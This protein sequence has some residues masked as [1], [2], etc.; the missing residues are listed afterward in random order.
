MELIYHNILFLLNFNK[1]RNLITLFFFY[2][3]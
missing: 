2:P 3:V 1:I